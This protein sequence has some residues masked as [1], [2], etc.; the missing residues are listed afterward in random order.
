MLQEVTSKTIESPYS[1]IKGRAGSVSRQASTRELRGPL[2][3][4]MTIE[5]GPIDSLGSSCIIKVL[6]F[7]LFTVTAREAT[8][9]EH[10]ARVRSRARATST[11][12]ETRSVF[13]AGTTRF[14]DA[15]PS[16]AP[17]GQ[18]G[19]APVGIF[20]Q[21]TRGNPRMIRDRGGECPFL[22]IPEKRLFFPLEFEIQS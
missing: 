19:A 4:S 16:I 20:G 13:R 18:S 17:F 7:R 22:R 8:T 6:I 5:L 10:H 11:R 9:V 14:S 12:R 21:S 15:E 2:D 1:E 3:R